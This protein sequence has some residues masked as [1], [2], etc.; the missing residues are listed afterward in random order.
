VNTPGR[1]RKAARNK[2]NEEDDDVLIPAR[3]SR[4]ILSVAQS[5]A[6]EADL[7]LSNESDDSE[8]CDVDGT[9]TADCDGYMFAENEENDTQKYLAPPWSS[10]SETLADIILAR[11]AEH[12]E[13]KPLGLKTNEVVPVSPKVAEVFTAVGSFL[14]RYRSGKFPKAFKII[15]RLQNWEEIL[16][17]TDPVHWTPNS[18]YRAAKLFASNLNADMAQRFFNLVLLPAIREDIQKNKRL[19]YHYYESLKKGNIQTWW[20]D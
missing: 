11:I 15:P 13:Q 17:L 4:R 20:M 18:M 8:E 10:R 9:S 5:Q 19:N 2:A 16:Y 12:T 7:D 14:S 1:K 3:L 6:Q